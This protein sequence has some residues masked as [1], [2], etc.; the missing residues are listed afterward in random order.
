[1]RQVRRRYQNLPA[2]YLNYGIQMKAQVPN[3]RRTTSSSRLVLAHKAQVFFDKYPA[4]ILTEEDNG[5][6]VFEYAKDYMGP[7]IS[8]TMPREKERFE[9]KEFPAFF[10]NFLPEGQNLEAFLKREKIDSKDY[11]AQLLATG[12]NLVGAVTVKELKR[13]PG[14]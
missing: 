9:F 11:F 4:G 12:S 1:M 5:R 14:T 10:D 7:A 13:K 6:Y 3:R 2:Q 8:R